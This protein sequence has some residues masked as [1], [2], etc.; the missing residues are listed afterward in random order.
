[1]RSLLGW[2]LVIAAG[3]WVGAFLIV[4][5]GDERLPY[6][7]GQTLTRPVICRVAFTIP[8]KRKTEEARRAAEE[9]APYSFRFNRA[10]AESIQAE[11]RNLHAAAKAAEDY[12]KFLEASA[13][14]WPLEVAGFDVLKSLTDEAGSERCKRN[15]D[16]IAERLAG[17]PMIANA[18]VDPEIRSTAGKVMLL[19]G[20]DKPTL[21]PKERLTYAANPDQVDRLARDLVRFVFSP[22][23]EDA[24]VTI[25]KKT[26]APAEGRV[27]PIY[28]FDRAFTKEKRAEQ[29]ASVAPVMDPFAPGDLLVQAR[30]LD[31][32]DLALLRAEH[33]EFLSRRRADATLFSQWRWKRLG[34]FGVVLMITIGLAVYTR[35]CQPRVLE[36]PARS[37]ALAAMLLIMLLADRLILVGM[38]ASPM[39]SVATITMTAAVLTI[40]Y[41]QIFAIGATTGLALLT[42]PI[43]GTSYSLILV[44]LTVASV[45]V[46][47]LREIRTRLR[48]VEVGGLSASAAAVSAY[49]VNLAEQQE[50]L[51]ASAIAALAAMAGIS[52]VMVLLP[53]IEKVFRITTS[54]TLLEWADTS[55]P[56]LRQLIEKA[57]GTWQHSH[58]LGSMAEKAAEEIGANGLL[59]RVGAYYHDVGKTCKPNYFVENQQAMMNAHRGLA[60]TMSL[61]VILAHVKDGLA[62]ARE[63][64]L[65]P[66]L[67]QFIAEHHGTTVVR[68]FHARATQEARSSGRAGR[69]IS[70]SEFR[71]PGP[72]P[73]SRESAILMLCDSTEGAVRAL[74]DP[75]PGR[76]ENVAHEILMAKLMDG[77]FNDCDITLR[78]LSCVE[79]SLVRSLCAIHHGRIA[80]PKSDEE[81]AAHARTA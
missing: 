25:V 63:Q 48:I 52:V 27:S 23:L 17:E 76:I 6:F 7:R 3:F 69:E 22:Q 20:D 81:T 32:D 44:L 15:V 59:V 5:S 58:L 38:D 37:L 24:L 46:L 64:R 18:G 14:R 39:W 8:N 28:E 42:I 4:S 21:V 19:R 33:D 61:L 73:H 72:K 41:S 47:L 57:P 11:F 2:P 51:K 43:F 53:V 10:L 29:L 31:D 12:E 71:Y 65:P 26:I 68:F 36:K 13:G 55:K 35:R 40:A 79:Q 49:L 62:L 78:Q 77:Q 75:T 9:S 45:T 56:L 50:A 80:Y 30:E 1:M 60:P 74:Q 16:A 67:H 70:E 66:V 54:L 34:L